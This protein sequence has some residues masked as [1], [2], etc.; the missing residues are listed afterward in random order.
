MRNEASSK[1]LESLKPNA[2][3][4]AMLEPLRNQMTNLA[5][6]DIHG[7]LLGAVQDIT[8]APDGHLNFL[9]SGLDTSNRSRLFLVT[10]DLV[11]KIEY[12]TQSI[13]INLTAK[14][15]DTLPE[16]VRIETETAENSE[17]FSSSASEVSAATYEPGTQLD[18][19]RDVP[20]NP[21]SP[22]DLRAPEKVAE[23]AIRLLEERLVVDRTK[24]K[25][26]DVIVRKEVETRMVEVPVRRE[27]L[28]VEQVTPERKQL[29]EIDLGQGEISG[30]DI[31]E[32]RGLDTQ[33]TVRSEFDSLQTA[34]KYLE[35]IAAQPNHGCVKVRVE[36][37][38]ENPLLLETYQQWSDRYAGSEP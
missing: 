30:V 14:Q 24:Q 32:I 21:F 9:V 10:S 26:G 25:V 5:V 31:G 4:A 23:E 36:L 11:Q 7:T 28:I 18:V 27:K 13:F 8:I 37:V 16:Y 35:A 33:P 15:A 34:S 38:L 1:R 17:S 2:R 29:A 19:S 22:E 12:A 20:E 3:L 6:R